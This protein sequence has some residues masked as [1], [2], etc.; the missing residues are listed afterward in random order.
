MES[1]KIVFSLCYMLANSILI[2]KDLFIPLV[3]SGIFYTKINPG[4][5][6]GSAREWW[7]WSL[8]SRPIFSHVRKA[9]TYLL[10]VVIREQME[11]R[12]KIWTGLFRNTHSRR[13]HIFWEGQFFLTL[14]LKGRKERTILDDAAR[15]CCV[16][17]FLT[18][19]WDN[20]WVIK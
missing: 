7:W 10:F 15:N 16:G 11:D 12:K 1:A 20:G 17:E 14:L 4:T 9:A 6:I 19:L 2:L 5:E 3:I 8:N 18:I 13:T